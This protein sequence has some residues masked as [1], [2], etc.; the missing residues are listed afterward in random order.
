[1]N[2]ELIEKLHKLADVIEHN[3]SIHCISTVRQAAYTIKQ[4]QEENEQYKARLLI[5]Y[6]TPRELILRLIGRLYFAWI[7]IKK[8]TKETKRS[9]NR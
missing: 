5:L 6:P 8:R 9:A 1:M 2:E 4:L 3:E 7:L